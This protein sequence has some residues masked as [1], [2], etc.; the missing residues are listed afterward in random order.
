MQVLIS[1]LSII[2]IIIA[3]GYVGARRGYFS[4]E[5]TKTASSL[6]MNVL[7]TA[8]VLESVFSEL[9]EFGGAEF[10]RLMLICTACMVITYI[11]GFLCAL[12]LRRKSARA[13]VFE[14]L[15]AAPNSMFIGAP[16]VR[17]LYGSGAVFYLI[18]TCIPFNVLLYTYGVW[19]MNQG[20]GTKIGLRD[21]L[22]MPLIASIAAMFIAIFRIKAPEFICDLCS[23][24]SGATVPM[25]MIVIGA[26][27][28]SVKLGKALTE[29]LTYAAA[30]VRLV[31]CPIVVWLILRIFVSDP[32]LLNTMIINAAVPSAIVIAVLAI[33]Y[34]R[35]A[36][37]ASEGILVS[38]LM[39]IITV[40]LISKLL[41]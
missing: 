28:G 10:A 1:Q 24:I 9:P 17:E 32:I 22:T 6:T 18:L 12:P 39:S 11:V 2:L 26:S 31:V 37:F 19:R 13:S 41:F 14:L 5:F 40:P 27:L 4:K 33:Q 35:D 23:I 21:M 29:P 34:D 3:I 30:L 25:S 7:L 15:I 8:M 38:M 16:L 20:G 36:E